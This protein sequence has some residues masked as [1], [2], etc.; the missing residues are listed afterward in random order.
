[1]KRTKIQRQL[2]NEAVY[3][4]SALRVKKKKVFFL[5]HKCAS[6]LIHKHEDSERSMRSDG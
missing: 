1:M 5:L 6:I 3:N 2:S 4:M